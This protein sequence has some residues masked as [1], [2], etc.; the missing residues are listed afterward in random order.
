EIRW[1]GIQLPAG[2]P[3]AHPGLA[4]TACTAAVEDRRAVGDRFRRRRHGVIDLRG[5]RVTMRFVLP[6]SS[7][8]ERPLGAPSR[9][10]NNRHERSGGR[11][12]IFPP[13]EATL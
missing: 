3:I 11:N 8:C 7:R 9:E 2:G 12:R 6:F 5:L 1:L 10:Q 13:G 4:M